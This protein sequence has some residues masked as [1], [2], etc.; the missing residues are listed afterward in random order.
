[1]RRLPW[2]VGVTRTPL[3]ILVGSWNTV[4]ESM[5]P[6]FL[7]SSIYSPLRGV[8]VIF[9]SDT[10]LLS[11]ALC[12]PAALMTTGAS[13]LPFAVSSFQS[14]PSRVMLSTRVSKKNSTPL[15]TAF[16]AMAQVSSKGQTMPLV[17]A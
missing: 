1:M 6:T 3:P 9:L 8:I 5:P 11:S 16:S 2:T 12:S 17:G 15:R 4:R 14:P 10:M 13:K 7:S